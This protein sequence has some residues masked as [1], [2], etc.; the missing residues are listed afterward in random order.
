MMVAMASH[1][2]KTVDELIDYINEFTEHGD[3][4]M[5]CRKLK[6]NKGNLSLMLRKKIGPRFDV[7]RELKKIADQNYAKLNG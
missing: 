5:V 4:A 3:K 2:V 6:Y 7:L 1:E